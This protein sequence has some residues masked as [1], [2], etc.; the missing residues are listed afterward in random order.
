MSDD[1]DLGAAGLR[2][3]PSSTHPQ[4][5]APCLH[6][7]SP[8]AG[9]LHR[10][11][12]TCPCPPTS[13]PPTRSLPTAIWPAPPQSQG[14]VCLRAWPPAWSSSLPLAS[15]PVSPV[16]P[17]PVPGLHTP[18][19]CAVSV[20]CAHRML[21]GTVG[22][23]R[24]VTTPPTSPAPRHPPLFLLPLSVS[25]DRGPYGDPLALS[26]FQ[27]GVTQG[28]RGL[29][30]RAARGPWPSLAGDCSAWWAGRSP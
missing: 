7:A 3:S 12:S 16:A 4:A 30:S 25:L 26:I 19:F 6:G 23:L 18:S 9:W 10:K 27:T 17:P 14:C 5:P 28:C 2:G 20:R 1:Q 24:A 13:S 11:S 21:P 8:C 22:G 29:C 15:W